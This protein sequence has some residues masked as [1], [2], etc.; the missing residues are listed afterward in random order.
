MKA[1]YGV[2]GGI[3][4]KYAAASARGSNVVPLNPELIAGFPDSRTVN[5]DLRAVLA[6]ANP[7]GPSQQSGKLPTSHR[8]PPRVTCWSSGAELHQG[9]H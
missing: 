1:E 6:Q 9:D 7:Q 4:V 3:R 2:R 8:S 5:D